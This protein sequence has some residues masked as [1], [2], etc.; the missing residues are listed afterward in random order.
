MLYC[1]LQLFG[2]KW[3]WCK[4]FRRATDLQINEDSV[5]ALTVGD[6]HF[7]SLDGYKYSFN[8]IGEFVYLRTDDKTFQSQIRFEQFRKANGIEKNWNRL[9]DKIKLFSLN[10]QMYLYERVCEFCILK[11]I[12]RK[13]VFAHPLYPNISIN[14]PS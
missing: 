1:L 8:G 11:E 5:S 4:F 10:L 9:I 6:P 3:C 12:S 7:T 2:K 14:R 13:Q